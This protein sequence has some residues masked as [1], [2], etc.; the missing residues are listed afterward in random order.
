M[1]ND[2]LTNKLQFVGKILFLKKII[3]LFNHR[4]LLARLII[5]HLQHRC[6]GKVVLVSLES[7]NLDLSLSRHVPFATATQDTAKSPTTH[8]VNWHVILLLYLLFRRIRILSIFFLPLFVIS[9]RHAL[10]Q[11][12]RGQWSLPLRLTMHM[13]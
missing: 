1:C 6:R 8:R 5:V 4:Y 13:L 7:V 10:N 9:T 11:T 3:I 12:V 2:V